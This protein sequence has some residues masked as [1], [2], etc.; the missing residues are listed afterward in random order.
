MKSQPQRC[1]A[2]AIFIFATKALVNIPLTH[3]HL[4]LIM[5]NFKTKSGWHPIVE[6]EDDS[7]KEAWF[8]HSLKFFRVINQ[9]LVPRLCGCCGAS[10]SST[11]K[12]FTCGG[13]KAIK[14]CSRRCQK[15]DR[16]AHKRTCETW[17]NS[18]LSREEQIDMARNGW[19]WSKINWYVKCK[20]I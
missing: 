15:N 9:L 2:V 12:L 20:I 11:Q 1:V 19:I 13:C 7:I 10:E 8:R 6:A 17:Y 3:F 16:A 5:L 14:Y 4:P 18:R